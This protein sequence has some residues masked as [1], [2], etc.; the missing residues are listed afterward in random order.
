MDFWDLLDDWKVIAFVG[1]ALFV[2]AVWLSM[3]ESRTGLGRALCRVFAAVCLIA[4]LGLLGLS[5]WPP[6][7][8]RNPQALKTVRRIALVTL[9][10]DTEILTGKGQEEATETENPRLARALAYMQFEQTTTAFKQSSITLLPAE[11]LLGTDAYR[12][13]PYAG[14]STRRSGLFASK[15]II[16]VADDLKILP[17]QEAQKFHGLAEALGVDALLIMQNRYELDWDWRDS[18]PLV[19]LFTDPYWYGNVRTRAWLV[20]REGN[21]IWRYRESKRSKIAER[22]HAYNYL[23]VSGS[24]ITTEQSTKLLTDAINESTSRFSSLLAQDVEKAKRQ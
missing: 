5:W 2:A 10:A 20:D 7:R 9:A 4:L 22:A 21:I 1:G 3:L 8:V 17:V 23:I 14:L 18:V 6:S 12:K 19:T 11:A 16:S 15:N 13:L 24:E